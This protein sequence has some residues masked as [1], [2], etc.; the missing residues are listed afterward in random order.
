MM[1]AY[2]YVYVSFPFPFRITVSPSQA[3]LGGSQPAPRQAAKATRWDHC[4]FCRRHRGTGPRRPWLCNAGGTPW[5][6]MSCGIFHG[7]TTV[8]MVKSVETWW[9]TLIN[10]QPSIFVWVPS[11]SDKPMCQSL[12]GN[13]YDLVE[14]SEKERDGEYHGVNQKPV[15]GLK[16]RLQVWSSGSNVQ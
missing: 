2:F 16:F 3:S 5:V 6:F 10:H 11:F 15:E 9:S 14:H 7:K 13:G 4:W 8:T 1:Y 12:L